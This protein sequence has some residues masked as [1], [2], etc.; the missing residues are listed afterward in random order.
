ME[1]Q[2][3]Q[4]PLPPQQPPIPPQ[5]I[6]PVPPPQ[7]SSYGKRNWL[8]WVFVYLT[9][10]VLIYG[11]IYYLARQQK[12]SSPYFANSPTPTISQPSPTPDLYTD[13][14]RSA[15]A[16]WKTY[17]DPEN[18]ITFSYPKRY[19][20]V[21]KKVEQEFS[22]PSPGVRPKGIQYS[23]TSFPGQKDY[24]FN[25]IET[26]KKEDF[27]SLQDKQCCESYKQ[28]YTLLQNVYLKKS[29]EGLGLVERNGY[30]FG[31]NIARKSKMTY[32]QSG[33][34]ALR[35]I[36]FF[37]RDGNGF[38]PDLQYRVIALDPKGNIVSL[39]LFLWSKEQQ[40]LSE[41]LDEISRSYVVDPLRIWDAKMDD[42]LYNQA[43]SVFTQEI[44]ESKQILSTFRF[45]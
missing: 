22:E 18:L 8:K 6:N 31:A 35:G 24:N 16:N 1:E 36:Y 38:G 30:F 4:Q 14:T 39:R 26:I 5:N 10:A 45:D 12:K 41:E 25:Y 37:I 28:T 17:S 40:R 23:F 11:G 19:G 21:A 9:I 15:T 33:D 2:N 44:N 32:I 29:A 3:Q 13:G 43:E 7:Q 34:S 42:L 27:T 20:S